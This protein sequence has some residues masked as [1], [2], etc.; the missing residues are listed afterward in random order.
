MARVENPVG[1]YAFLPGISPYSAG[2]RAAPGHLIRRF[3]L[4]RSL[5]WRA[6]FSVIDGVLAG[7]GRPSQALCSIELRCPEPASFDGFGS[8][9]DDYRGA[10]ADRGI[11]LDDGGVNPVARTNVA[12]GL[13]PP[14]ETH[15]H[16]FG[17]TVPDSDSATRRRDAAGPVS[18]IVSG[19]GDLHDQADLRPETIVGG[20]APWAES[21]SARATAVL[22]EIDQ[23]LSGLGLTWAETDSVAVYSTEAVTT[24]LEPV[25][26]ARLGVAQHRGVQLYLAQPPIAGLLFEMDARGGVEEHWVDDGWIEEESA[27]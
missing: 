17:F 15:L 1:G 14:T 6:G 27:L 10:L 19:A 18:F 22:D 20:A 25:V 16:A 11:L 2:V 3:S 24:V 8:F 12:P 23:R 13:D 9:N 4:R 5:P 7:E 21:G 26:F